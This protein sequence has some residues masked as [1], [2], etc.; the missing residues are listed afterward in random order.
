MG[1]ADCC[2]DFGDIVGFLI[3]LNDSKFVIKSGIYCIGVVGGDDIIYFENGK[4]EIFNKPM[5]KFINS[6]IKK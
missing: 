1:R 6:F 2:L 5:E 4:F 3:F